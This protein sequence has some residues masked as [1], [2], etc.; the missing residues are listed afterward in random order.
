[1]GTE[2]IEKL[3]KDLAHQFGLGASA[4]PLVESFL[5]FLSYQRQDG[6]AG[7]LEDFRDYGQ[8]A[9]VDSWLGLAS[10]RPITGEDLTEIIGEDALNYLANKS[11]LNAQTTADALAVAV[12]RI[13]D[14]LSPNGVIPESLP[15]WASG[16]ISIPA[17]A[18][19]RLSESIAEDRRN[20]PP[21]KISEPEP[22]PSK[23]SK[24]KPSVPIA[25]TRAVVQ[26]RAPVAERSKPVRKPWAPIVVAPLYLIGI[27]AL[28]AGYALYRGRNSGPAEASP[29]PKQVVAQGKST[30]GTR[31]VATTTASLLEP[32]TL[33]LSRSGGLIRYS[34]IV[35]EDRNR[36]NILLAL[37]GNEADGTIDVDLG[38]GDSAW[39]P[40]IAEIVKDFFPRGA[41]LTF[42]G[43]EVVIGGNLS[44]S[45]LERLREDIQALVGA[46]FSVKRLDAAK[47]GQE[48]NQLASA[49]IEELGAKDSVTETDLCN[50][51]NKMVVNF[52]SGSVAVP[53]LNQELLKLAVSLFAKLPPA[54]K[55]EIVGHTDSVGSKAG[56]QRL[57]ERRAMEVM[58]FLITNGV[59]E[60]R[61]VSFGA[62]ASLPLSSN[63]TQM[64]R[65][66][67]RRIEF[68]TYVPGQAE[69][70]LKP[71]EKAEELP[72]S[73]DQTQSPDSEGN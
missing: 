16:R 61:L 34:G 58:R 1:M 13:I 8:N 11:G 71:P 27:V 42:S 40:Y 25:P 41:E 51:L 31:S 28:I 37:G 49:R 23:G 69:A 2:G 9:E 7:L 3:T 26:E 62:G 52:A 63:D 33:N 15:A 60:E 44:E 59:S 47:I 12:P 45:R 57:S 66:Q 30:E 18:N 55:I 35:K 39:I 20:R 46:E 53:E 70:D 54:A 22:A 32:A 17:A 48:A 50:A 73:S 68:R 21:T 67:N 5:G 38:V 56:N 14:L 10:N 72:I 6:L 19:K 64:G 24:L 29:K 65:F 4:G 36:E 43:S